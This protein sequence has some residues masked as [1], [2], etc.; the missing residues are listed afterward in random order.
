MSG[1]YWENWTLEDAAAAASAVARGARP[2]PLG[3]NPADDF[4]DEF[5]RALEREAEAEWIADELATEAEDK[6]R[7]ERAER[8]ED[9][10]VS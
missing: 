1:W 5:V 7:A 4:P 3:R 6:A 10:R 9:W 8:D 2:G